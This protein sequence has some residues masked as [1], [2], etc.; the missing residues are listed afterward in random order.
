MDPMPASYAIRIRG[1]LGDTVL[2]AFPALEARRHGVDTV[3]TG[4][5]DRSALYGVLAEVESLGLDLIEVRRSLVGMDTTFDTIR[6]IGPPAA[7][8][9]YVALDEHDVIHLHDYQRIYAVPGLYEH[10][11]QE[12]LQCRSPQVAAE[13]FLRAIAGLSMEPSSLT[14]LDFGSGT[15]LVGELLRGGGVGRVVGVDALAAGR[16]ACLRDRPGVYA[17]Y[18]IGDIGSG[19]L[20]GQLRAHAP[21]GLVSAGAFG[22]THAPPAALITALS[23]L[24]AGAPMAVTIDERWL[25]RADPAGFGAAIEQLE[26]GG[27]LLLLERQRFQHRV[28][29]TGEPIFY[30]LIVGTTGK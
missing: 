29:T 26:E 8:G 24:P 21:G 27:D 10:I 15:G 13:G 3:L 7:D 18:L 23:V 5:L 16:A 14:V 28:T 22:G 30:E 11:V 19:S 1:H 9:E 20:S 6:L 12:R 4:L 2:S 17:D 25:D